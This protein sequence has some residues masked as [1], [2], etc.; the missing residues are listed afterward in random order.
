[1]LQRQ[2][3]SGSHRQRGDLDEFPAAEQTRPKNDSRSNGRSSF[4][5][6]PEQCPQSARLRA[7]PV[8]AFRPHL[9]GC[10]LRLR[11]LVFKPIFFRYVVESGRPICPAPTGEA[12][13]RRSRFTAL[14]PMPVR[15]GVQTSRADLG[16]VRR[17]LISG[18]SDAAHP[19]SRPARRC[20]SWPRR[21]GD[22]G[23]LGQPRTRCHRKQ[24]RRCLELPQLRGCRR[25]PLRPWYR[26]RHGCYEH[27]RFRRR[28]PHGLPPLSQQSGTCQHRRIGSSIGV[29]HLHR[30]TGAPGPSSS[31]AE[32]QA[33]PSS[34]LT[35]RCG[36]AVVV[37]TDASS[38]KGVPAARWASPRRVSRD[39][40]VSRAFPSRRE[41]TRRL[42]FGGAWSGALAARSE[43]STGR[44]CRR[45]VGAVWAFAEVRA[46]LCG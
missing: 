44:R 42:R 22:A 36:V 8:T 1:M 38:R 3:P 20:S 40:T 18:T 29:R 2:R 39:A 13:G 32:A 45:R 43:P 10:C 31:S 9:F 4:F 37:G 35:R 12:P 6:G 25:S 34:R 15:V 11:P 24:S 7:R 28:R 26:R 46:A 33:T 30:P 23:L 17:A 41:P 14:R 27:D 16:G 5:I 19:S 21:H